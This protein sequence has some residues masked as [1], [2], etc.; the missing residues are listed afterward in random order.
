MNRKEAQ[1][2]ELDLLVAIALLIGGLLV[3]KSLYI[4]TIDTPQLQSTAHDAAF[5]LQARTISTMDHELISTI[6]NDL[7]GTGIQLNSTETIGWAATRLILAGQEQGD[8]LFAKAASQL[9]SAAL[10]N[11]LQGTHYNVTILSGD[12]RYALIGTDEPITQAATRSSVLIT[13]LELNKP[14]YGYTASAYL[15]NTQA[16]QHTYTYFGGFVGQGNITVYLDLPAEASS[17]YLEGDFHADFDV[18]ANGERCTHITVPAN[19]DPYAAITST[20]LDACLPYLSSKVTGQQ[21]NI[22]TFNFTTPETSNHY[23]GGGYLKATHQTDY[24]YNPQDRITETYHLPGI[25]GIFNLFDAVR[26]PGRLTKMDID[27]HY[28]ANHTNTHNNV[29]FTIGDQQLYTD[30]KS[31]TPQ[32]VTINDATLRTMINYASYTNKTIPFR[33]GYDNGSRQIIT[34]S[35]IDAVAVTDIS[36]SMDWQFDQ[37]SAGIARTCDDPNLYDLSTKRVSVAKCAGKNFTATLLHDPAQDNRLGLTSYS[38]TLRDTL[39]FTTDQD[40]INSQIDGYTAGGSTCICC[41]I[42]G[43]E[44]LFTSDNER[45]PDDPLTKAIIIMTDGEATISCASTFGSVGDLDGDGNADGNDDYAVAAACKAHQDLN[46]SIYAVGFGRDNVIDEQALQAMAACDNA[47]H[48]YQATDP[49]SLVTIYNDIAKDIIKTAAYNAQ[50]ITLPEHEQSSIIYPDSTITYTYEPYQ[51]ADLKGQLLITTEQTPFTKGCE[52]QQA[53]IPPLLTPLTSAVTSYSGSHWTDLLTINNKQLYALQDYGSR[54]QSLGDPYIISV[55]TGTLT[56]GTNKL[57][58]RT[59]DAPDNG[60]GCSPYDKLI[61]TAAINN[62]ITLNTIHA[63]ATGCNWIV[64]MPSEETKTIPIPTSY[65]G[66]NTCTYGP[67]NTYDEGDVWQALGHK[68]FSSLDLNQDGILDIT[69]DEQGLSLTT[70]EQGRIPYL[71]GPAL[72]EVTVWH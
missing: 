33:F 37:N 39:A 66:T 28:F 31:T 61:Y 23:I 7:A 51:R 59:A 29:F 43:A 9:V 64:R 55:P 34:A 8:P 47:S 53:T 32:Q 3:V 54:Y 48:Y 44:N 38:T 15:T 2:M 35:A 19:P 70:Q 57:T 27:L 11:M 72:L 30:N 22:F 67:G 6:N 68:L 50:V 52:D 41:G 26:I 21:R 58:L 40:A 17:L 12:Q 36:G 60:K 4:H 62:T 25:K 46:A 45:N 69:F 65:E 10:K 16:E 18:Y 20:S 14:V 56:K 13:G 42:L 49:E 71:W 5:S 24:A 63:A 1:L